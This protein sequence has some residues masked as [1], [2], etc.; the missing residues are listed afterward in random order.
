MVSSILPGSIHPNAVRRTSSIER[1][2]QPTAVHFKAPTE[3]LPV[4]ATA[5]AEPVGAQFVRNAVRNVGP[6]VV[7]ID[8]DRVISQERQLFSD[9]REGDTVKVS[10]TGKVYECMS[11]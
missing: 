8:C 7:R 11:V 9:L 10:G 2:V 1:T 4:M 6:S 3:P 5:T